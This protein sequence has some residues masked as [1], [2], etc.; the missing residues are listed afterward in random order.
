MT[1]SRCHSCAALPRCGARSPPAA[2]A[3]GLCRAGEQGLSSRSLL[4][5]WDTS[6]QEPTPSPPWPRA[7]QRNL[8]FQKQVDLS[9]ARE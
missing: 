1:Q 8:F 7:T 3:P 2:R 6:E 9:A 4:S 5:C